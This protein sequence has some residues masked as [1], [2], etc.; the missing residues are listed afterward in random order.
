MLYTTP[1]KNISSVMGTSPDEIDTP[2][3][4]SDRVLLV[5]VIILMIFGSLAVYSSIA[6]FAESNQTSAGSLVISHLVKLSIAFLGMLI[7]SKI[8]YHTLAKFSRLG[9]VVSWVLLIGVFFFGAEV[10]GARRSLSI[11]GFSFQPSSLA[12]VALLIHIAVLV[13]E[14]QDYIKDFKRAFLPIMFWVVITCGLIGIEDFSSAAVLMGLSMLVMFVG[15]VSTLQL[16]SLLII[17]LLGASVLIWQ[18][19]E[20]QSRIDHYI[21]QVVQVKSDEFNVAEGYQAQQAHIAIAQGEIFGVGIGKSTQRDFLPA[22]YNDFIFAIIAEEYGFVGSVALLL[23]FTLILFRGIAKIAKNAPDTL[24]MLMAV[25]CTLT[26]ALYGFVNAGVASGLLPVTGL[27]MPFVSYGGTST[28]FSGLMIGIL[29]NISK[30][31]SGKN[32]VFYA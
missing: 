4:G 26:I 31:S 21:D 32:A 11:G 14:K 17:G 6:F 10:F 15:R 5:S 9:M 18:S 3:Q 19:P 8:N 23:L 2:A 28:L 30:H 27:P 16:G 7:A 1:N 24:G 13:D 25:G 29:L 12:T 20:R 22:P